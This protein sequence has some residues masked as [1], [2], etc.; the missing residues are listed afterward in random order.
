[1]N[2]MIEAMMWRCRLRNAHTPVRRATALIPSAFAGFCIGV[3]LLQA[4]TI[5]PKYQ[6]PSPAL[7]PPAYKEA[8]QWKTAQPQDAALKGNWWEVFQDAQLNTLEEQLGKANQT[9]RAAQDTYLQARAALRFSRAGQYPQAAAGSLTS[10]QRQSSN[11]PLRGATSP[12]DFSD[13]VLSSDVSY[14]ADVWGGSAG[15]SKPAARRRR[16]APPIWKRFA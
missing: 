3:T 8:G 10:R 6:K 7:V 1:M 13:F 14:E 4:C 16:P 2:L 15:P 5:G 9:L 11:R 12:S